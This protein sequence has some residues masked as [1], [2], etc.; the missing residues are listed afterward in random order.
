M[1]YKDGK[2]RETPF[3]MLKDM[4]QAKN[5]PARWNN[6]VLDI[7]IKKPVTR[8]RNR[9]KMQKFEENCGEN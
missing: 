2:K 9:Q 8:G 6:V 4:R 5:S 1:L 7:T 3:S